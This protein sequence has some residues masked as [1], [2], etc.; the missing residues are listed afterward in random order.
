MNQTRPD[1]AT[2]LVPGPM[3][4]LYN[5]P[6]LEVFIQLQLR[7]SL[8]HFEYCQW[9]GVAF[10]AIDEELDCRYKGFISCTKLSFILSKIR[11]ET[12]GSG[13]PR[14]QITLTMYN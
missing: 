9:Q 2:M 14:R 6:K 4:K 12:G 10:V 11:N 13:G 1:V 5:N 7:N 8:K 3:L